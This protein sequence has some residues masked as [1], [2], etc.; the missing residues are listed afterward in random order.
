MMTM[1]T[2]RH[3]AH[4]ADEHSMRLRCSCGWSGNW[5][6]FDAHIGFDPSES[7]EFFDPENGRHWAIVGAIVLAGGV[8]LGLTL[9]WLSSTS[10]TH[11]DPAYSYDVRCDR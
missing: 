2:S 8:L 7:P 1:K 3:V 10:D 6:E 11:H 9:T 4:W 5:K